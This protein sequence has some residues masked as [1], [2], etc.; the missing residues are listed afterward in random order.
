M[1]ESSIRGWCIATLATAGI[2]GTVAVVTCAW[3]GVMAPVS[4]YVLTAI[5]V[6]FMGGYL[7]GGRPS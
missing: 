6:G 2:L 1:E 3:A 4:L 5:S 7:A